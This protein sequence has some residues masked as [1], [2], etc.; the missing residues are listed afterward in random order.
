MPTILTVTGSRGSSEG[1][2]SPRPALAM[3]PAFFVLVNSD[4]VDVCPVCLSGIVC[5]FRD[6]P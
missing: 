5:D 2:K 3:F 4:S 6:F 1:V